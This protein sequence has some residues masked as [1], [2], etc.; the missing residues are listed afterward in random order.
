MREQRP[1]GVLLRQS[2]NDDDNT[3][4]GAND[5]NAMVLSGE[6][7]DMS[8]SSSSSQ[9]HPTQSNNPVKP[10]RAQSNNP[11]K[12]VRAPLDK[13]MDGLGCDIQVMPVRYWE[14]TIRQQ[15][16]ETPTQWA[17]RLMVYLNT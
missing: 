7:G 13:E 12:S 3:N 4:A 2:G 6:G 11:V 8:S 1:S 10:V 15:L 16:R 5:D 9:S 14:D 17:E